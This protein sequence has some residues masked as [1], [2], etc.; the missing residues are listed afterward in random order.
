MNN[1]AVHFKEIKVHR[2]SGIGQGEGFNLT[3]LAPGV[4]LVH[5]PNGS[6]KSTTAKVIQELLW[7][8][9]TGLERPTVAGRFDCDGSEWQVE[10]DAGHRTVLRDGKADAP[11][12]P[13]GAEYRARY[14]LALHDLVR[15]TDSDSKF[16]AAI[17][18]ESQ[19]GYDLEDAASA[20]GFNAAPS[21]PSKEYKAVIEVYKKVDE[22]TRQ[23]VGIQNQ[24]S[25]LGTLR[26]ERQCAVAADQF[27]GNLQKALEYHHFQ[28]QYEQFEANLA[29]MP[30][31]ISRL[32]GNEREQLDELQQDLEKWQKEL[33]T[34]Q[35]QLNQA[36]LEIETCGLPPEMIDDSVIAA[37][38]TDHSELQ[39][40]DSKIN[41]QK[42]DLHRAC[43]EAE[44]ARKRISDHVTDEQ[45]GLLTSLQPDVRHQIDGF[46]GKVLQVR[47]ETELL[48]K[49]RNLLDGPEP[50]EIQG[51]TLDQLK[52]GADALA[53]WLATPTSMAGPAQ[54]PGLTAPFVAS[55]VL[56]G[57]L[58]VILAIIHHWGWGLIALAVV[59]L[60]GWQLLSRSS[61]PGEAI[62]DPRTGH[63]DRYDRTG[64]E[65]P[66]EWSAQSIG[67]LLNR[68]LAMSA[69]RTLAD[70]R[71]EWLRRL[72]KDEQALE[73]KQ[74]QLDTQ[75]L[76]IERAIGLKV[77]MED[78][79]LSILIDNLIRWQER[80]ATVAGAKSVL[81]NLIKRQTELLDQINL[82]LAP[83]DEEPIHSL[84]AATQAIENL[85]KRQSKYV[86]AQQQRDNAQGHLNDMI[87]PALESVTQKRTAIYLKLG[88]DESQE[89]KL[90]QWLSDLAAFRE[91]EKNR[92][93]AR[94]DRDRV[95]QS[96][97]A[98]E[99]LLEIHIGEIQRQITEYEKLAARRDEL[100][101]TISRIEN[102]I[103][104]A[105]AGHELV[106]I[107]EEKE[108]RM[109]ELADARD[110]CGASIVGSVLTDWLR[111]SAIE[112]SRPAV[113]QRAKEV[114][115]RF[116]HGELDLDLDDKAIPAVFLAGS[117]KG[118]KRPVDHLSIGERVQLLMA[119]RLAFLEH[120]ESLQ[121]PLLLDETL[122]TS[123]DTRAGVIIDSVIELAKMGRQVFYFTAQLDEVGK[124][125]SRLN[126]AGVDFKKTDL[127]DVRKLSA[128]S[129]R[130][131]S[132]APV[133]TVPLPKPDGLTYIEYGQALGVSGINPWAASLDDLHVW[134]LLDDVNVL[135]K[136]MSHHVSTW[137]QLQ[138]LLATG[139]VGIFDL[140]DE[141]FDHARAKAKAIE[142]AVRCWRI[143]RG[144]PV[145]RSV[146][147]ESNVASEAFVDRLTELAQKCRGDAKRI[148]TCLENKEVARWR[149]DNT[150]RLASYF[151]EHG[152]L[153]QEEPMTLD[154]VRI[155]V[156]AAIAE[157]LKAG[158]VK[159]SELNLM[160]AGL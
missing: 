5:G 130:P 134:H 40:I 86:F 21:K 98:H 73:A 139:G 32:N 16:A 151:E 74:G 61:R 18:R 119:V 102:A 117:P 153:S 31:E 54:G 142:E 129:A 104:E 4:N 122:G 106:E 57:V 27:I 133:E 68:L 85:R 159:Q 121:L 45:L 90:D 58:G 62:G 138:T 75:R 160:L 157:P 71:A 94:R 83:L 49:Q 91:L 81:E 12:S 52:K 109:A 14:H 155:R 43:G 65:S 15:T 146:I 137:G 39:R 78:T 17:V 38:S 118:L 70:E 82:R 64:L 111:T 9:Q 131:L 116:S 55:V 11:P 108:A 66:H 28:Q 140:D 105:K 37:I 2:V 50:K 79:W 44:D 25:T 101:A 51:F 97:R 59:A 33:V 42:A 67:S 156:M 48:R 120:D 35:Q 72:A 77:A 53:D 47:A 1:R 84:T 99:D 93:A 41:Q 132:I 80:T 6:G 34:N 20:L 13:G 56:V 10:I 124:W 88:I 125:I 113:F 7:H 19:G 152:Y 89:F 127:A 87:R 36:I 135:H 128:V 26:E 123:D 115:A 112:V 126:A 92:E 63:R 114:L 23:Q 60:V 110:R 100:T 149:A 103:E 145:D 30:P 143:G 141:V 107:L 22:A 136:L 144:K 147:Q 76:L 46:V 24:E 69:K 95:R 8:G 96:L 3:D 154:Q 150:D 158:L 148:V 29:A